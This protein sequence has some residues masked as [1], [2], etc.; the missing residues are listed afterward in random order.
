MKPSEHYGEVGI[1][2][3]AGERDL[4]RDALSDPGVIMAQPFD[5]TLT[6]YEDSTIIRMW[7]ESRPGVPVTVHGPGFGWVVN[8]DISEKPEIPVREEDVGF[9]LHAA[10]RILRDRTVHG[11]LYNSATGRLRAARGIV[12]YFVEAGY[13]EALICQGLYGRSIN[14]RHRNVEK[15]L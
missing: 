7:E 13:P 12:R 14:A 10:E 15:L 5:T 8:T 6:G 3:T 2:D 9:V 1:I 11:I 4:V